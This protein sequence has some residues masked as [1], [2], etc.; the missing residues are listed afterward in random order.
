LTAI[1][2]L[3]INLGTDI[4]PAIALG[5]DPRDDD[6]MQRKPR[7]PQSLVL[8]NSFLKRLFMI[9][10]TIGLFVIT[11]FIYTLI[12][13]GWVW[14][15]DFDAETLKHG[16]TLAFA[17]LVIIQLMNSFSVKSEK[18]IKLKQLFNNHFHF[19]AIMVSMLIVLAVVYLPFFNR[20]L[21]TM[22]LDIHDW[23]V[24]GLTSIIPVIIFEIIKRFHNKTA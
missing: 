23:V 17:T 4:L 2:I 21:G 15:T 18:P 13:D 7:D 12:S 5:V 14:G 8:N 9:G 3:T 10:G 6:V 11:A 19:F 16:Q 20:V 1:L 22:P 24:I